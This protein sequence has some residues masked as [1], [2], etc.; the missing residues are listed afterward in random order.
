[1]PEPGR[2]LTLVAYDSPSGTRRRRLSAALATRGHRIQKSVF[3]VWLSDRERGQLRD[4]L[5]RVASPE[6][7]VVVMAVCA[8]CQSLAHRH[9][10]ELPPLVRRWLVV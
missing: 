2:H 7:S 5:M 4:T 10:A 3:L 6:D 1:M 8:R 9:N